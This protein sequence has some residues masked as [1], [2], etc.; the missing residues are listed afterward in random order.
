MRM[1]DVSCV[2]KEGED[3]EEATFE[4]QRISYGD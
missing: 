1:K 2:P 3:E 4:I